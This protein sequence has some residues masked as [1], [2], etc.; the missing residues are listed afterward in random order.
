[1]S[2]VIKKG[3]GGNT[4]A[5]LAP[6]GS[7]LR[8]RIFEVQPEKIIR[9][10]E[11][12]KP[13]LTPRKK[14]P[15][16]P[17]LRQQMTQKGFVLTPGGYRPSSL[18]QHVEPGQALQMFVPGEVEAEPKL[19]DLE[20]SRIIR[21]PTQWPIEPAD[22]PALGSGW[23]TYS[24]W[25]NGS[26]H[27]I[28]SFKTT[29]QVPP[30]PEHKGDQ[31]IFLFNGMQNYGANFG[32][33]Q[34]V[35]HW[36][37]PVAGEAPRWWAGCWYVTSGG[38][39][40]HS[41]LVPV[42]PGDTLT[43]VIRTAA[44]SEYL[45]NYHCYFEGLSDTL[46]PVHGITELLQCNEVLEAYSITSYADYPATYNT[47][48][49]HI[50]I[51]T[52]SGTPGVNW[53]PVDA[54]TDCGQHCVI[55]NNSAVDGEV[56]LFYR[57]KEIMDE[58]SVN[59]P[60]VAEFGNRLLVA[61]AGTDPEHR[62]NIV[63]SQEEDVWIDK[64]TLDD[65]ASAGASLCVFRDRLYLAWAGT[66]NQRL[67]IMSSTNGLFW[68]QKVTLNETSE[69]RPTLTV[70]RD[71]LVLA[72]TGTDA[73]RRLNVLF[74]N[75]GLNWQDKRT[76]AEEAIDAPALAAFHD[77]L[78]VAWTGTNPT[79]NLNILS[80]GDE[81]QT[82]QNKVTLPETSVAGPSLFAYSNQ[83]YLSWAGTDINHSLNTIQSDDGVLFAEKVTLW[84]SSDYTPVL[85]SCYEGDLGVIWTGRD[86]FRHLNLMTL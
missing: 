34:P 69:A 50:N 83:L 15:S 52:D 47:R 32:L 26:G 2:T 29:W 21:K 7:I 10:D 42:K 81:G 13:V 20:S 5:T 35:L 71:R 65:T 12:G 4:G 39:A 84:D 41:T 19:I 57:F 61:W 43:G 80:S 58:C 55:M 62:L 17:E 25:N 64:L 75:D 77:R 53:T 72:W 78:F 63:Q 56:A 85:C 27:P 28:T 23:I 74:S 60:G 8:S 49:R 22:L 46:L 86:A 3:S 48:L 9:F 70:F 68:E 44:R 66:G 67:N 51:L 45:F 1:M 59:A 79:R 73:S 6:M 33:L 40:F 38:F 31:T 36:G 37:A 16:R 24:Y 76:L 82:W 11:L 30:E 14:L 54:V 18:V